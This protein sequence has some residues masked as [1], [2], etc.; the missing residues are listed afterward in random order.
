MTS[1]IAGTTFT[2]TLRATMHNVTD[3]RTDRRQE[4]M[5]IADQYCV[6]VR[7]AKK[8]RRQ[9]DFLLI[10]WPPIHNKMPCYRKDDRAMRPVA[11]MGGLKIFGSPWIAMP[12]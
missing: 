2:P 9:R 5:P 7:S 11:Y 4:M 6:A 12:I 8:S 1:L 3:R 10:H